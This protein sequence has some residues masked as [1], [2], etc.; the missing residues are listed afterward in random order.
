MPV[1]LVCL[2]D[3]T[4][5]SSLLN[6]TD[7]KNLYNIWRRTYR[8]YKEPNTDSH[9]IPHYYSYKSLVSKRKM[10]CFSLSVE[11]STWVP[12][13]LRSPFCNYIL[14]KTP[15]IVPMPLLRLVCLQPAWGFLMVRFSFGS[16]SLIINFSNKTLEDVVI[17]NLGRNIQHY[18]IMTR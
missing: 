7:K 5:S 13:C 10:M 8:P 18:L 17:Q 1:L 15:C 14:H 3:Y 9:L 16:Y 4:L 11:V 6:Y 2:I 12:C